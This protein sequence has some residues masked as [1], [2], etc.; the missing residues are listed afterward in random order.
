MH[1]NV[2]EKIPASIILLP[3]GHLLSKK[4][5]RHLQKPIIFGHLIIKTILNSIRHFTYYWKSRRGYLL[6]AKKKM[7]TGLYISEVERP[8]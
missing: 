8:A 5:N 2:S 7:I 1:I 3:T 4:Q 6:G